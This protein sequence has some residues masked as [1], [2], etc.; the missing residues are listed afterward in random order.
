MPFSKD[1]SL[2]LDGILAGIQPFSLIDD[3]KM[4][5]I[6]TK[7]AS[8]PKVTK[9]KTYSQLLLI[10]FW[11]FLSSE[12][13]S[14]DFPECETTSGEEWV[15]SVEKKRQWLYDLHAAWLEPVD[16]IYTEADTGESVDLM[17][18]AVLLALNIVKQC[19]SLRCR[20][21]IWCC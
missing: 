19:S 16:T 15:C 2:R 1:I 5:T 6:P 21:L 4:W 3:L 17:N 20:R 13:L 9:Q 14:F 11:F 8:V 7:W 18:P 10:H 12:Q